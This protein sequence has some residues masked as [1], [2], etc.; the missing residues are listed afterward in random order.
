MEI[1]LMSWNTALYE[2]NNKSFNKKSGLDNENFSKAY[3]R[4]TKH[5][6]K[7]NAVAVLQEIP[8]KSNINWE[9]HPIFTQVKKGFPANK[10]DF[11]YNLSNNNQIMMTVVVAKKRIIENNPNGINTNRFV[12]FNIKGISLVGI[13]SK[14]ADQLRKALQKIKGYRPDVIIGDFNAG[15]YYLNDKNKDD[16]IAVNR[17]NYLLLTEGYIDL[18]QGKVTTTYNTYIDHILMK[19]NYEFLSKC[20]CMNVNVDNKDELSDHFPIYCTIETDR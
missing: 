18:C 9:E 14:N 8:F 13:H 7:E 19:S 6:S 20:K 1:N 12:S 3:E 17:K 16:K 5:L 4:I 2:F 15:N 11:L 10:Y